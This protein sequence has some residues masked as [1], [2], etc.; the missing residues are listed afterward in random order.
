M[1]YIYIL[2]FFSTVFRSE[3]ALDERYTREKRA[4]VQVNG[5]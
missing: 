2:L 4:A 3:A 5:I 1:N